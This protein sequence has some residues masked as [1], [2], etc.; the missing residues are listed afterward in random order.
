MKKKTTNYKHIVFTLIRDDGVTLMKFNEIYEE[1]KDLIRFMIVAKEGGTEEV[2]YPHFQGYIQFYRSWRMKGIKML[3]EDNRVHIE[4]QK[5]TNT[6]ARNYCWKGELKQGTHKP[7]VSA[8]FECYGVFCKGQGQRTE[9]EEIKKD[10]EKGLSHYDIVQDT[11][12]FASYGRY[13]SWFYK[14]KQMCDDKRYNKIRDPLQ[15]EV[16]FGDAGTGKT[17]G[18]L[19]GEG[20]ENCYILR[21]PNKDNKSWN[22]YD[23]QEVLV[24][25]DFYGWLPLNDILNILDNKPYRVRKLGDYSWARWKRVYITSNV[26][27][28]DWY[29]P[30]WKNE[31]IIEALYSRIQKCSE[32][33]RGNTGALVIR[34][35]NNETNRHNWSEYFSLHPSAPSAKKDGTAKAALFFA[36]RGTRFGGDQLSS[37]DSSYSDQFE[38]SMN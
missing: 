4:E 30:N 8:V 13:H 14:Y 37:E 35:E 31:K 19:N 36:S 22:G 18:I 16:I 10:L 2:K 5:G 17:T 3:L 27:M 7:N 29:K 33:T 9:M 1:N 20:V 34:S 21:N 28:K 6:E 15:V 11:G 38:L 12:K 24:I 25:D 26:G 32:V 23:G